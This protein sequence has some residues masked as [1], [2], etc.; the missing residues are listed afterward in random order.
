ME[1]RTLGKSGLKVSVVGLGCNN[2]GGRCD[3]DQTGAV[4]NRAL[5]EGV[6]LFDTADC[7]PPMGGGR[8]GDS[9]SLLGRFL[10]VRRRDV[11]IATKFGVPMGDGPYT[12]GSSRRYIRLAVEASLKRLGTDHIDL[13]QVHMPDF[14]TPEQE[15]LGALNDLVCAGK[16][17]Y[18][19]CSNYPAWRVA[20]SILLS[21]AN[22]LASYVS[23]QNEYS[24]LNRKVE[25]ELTPA[26]LHL[27]V[28]VLPYFPLASGFLTGKYRRGTAAPNDSRLGLWSQMA[29]RVLTEANFTLLERLEK[30]VR[31]RGHTL[32]ELAMSWLAARPAVSSVIAGA[33][34]PE[35]VSENIRA[36]SWKLTGEEIAEI[37][38]LTRR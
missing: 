28:G 22:G 32:V 7:Y 31:D 38:K 34:R 9:E 30:F 13:Y 25:E 11:V 37:D 19:G 33:T 16:V 23:A 4:I 26:C 15:T 3:A 1:Y 36:A 24:L 29:P 6:T 17:R 8:R 14:E 35:H 21:R 12:R 2:F 20:E 5:E 10:G 27:G 18:I